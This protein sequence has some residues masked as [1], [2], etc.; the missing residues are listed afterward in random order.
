MRGELYE[1]SI[2]VRMVLD[3]RGRRLEVLGGSDSKGQAHGPL[4]EGKGRYVS[5]CLL[6]KIQQVACPLLLSFH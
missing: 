5:S 2:E 4:F 3:N 1:G 6:F